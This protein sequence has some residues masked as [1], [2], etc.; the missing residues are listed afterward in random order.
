MGSIPIT[1]PTFPPGWIAVDR[2]CG[3]HARQAV[4]P[5]E[6]DSVHAAPVTITCSLALAK[7]LF[8]VIEQLQR[9]FVLLVDVAQVDGGP[10]A[11]RPQVG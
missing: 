1:R 11:A 5:P 3:G 7:V 10:F 8:D 2:L 6:G 4:L 9:A